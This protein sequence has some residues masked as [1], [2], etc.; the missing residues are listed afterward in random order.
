M[1]QFLVA[2]VGGN[3]THYRNIHKQ[4]Y[5]NSSY[6]RCIWFEKTENAR[7]TLKRVRSQNQFRSN[8]R[9]VCQ[10]NTNEIHRKTEK[11]AERN[12]TNAS[13]KRSSGSNEPNSPATLISAHNLQDSGPRFQCDKDKLKTV[14]DDAQNIKTKDHP[15]AIIS[16][17]SECLAKRKD[18][19]P[20]E[21]FLSKQRSKTKQLETGKVTV[22]NVSELH[23]D[24][25]RLK[26][27]YGTVSES[28]PTASS[29]DKCC[30]DNDFTTASVASTGITDQLD[31]VTTR[32]VS[33]GNEFII[34]LSCET[35][36]NNASLNNN[37]YYTF[38]PN[39]ETEHKKMSLNQP[40]KQSD[41]NQET[42]NIPLLINTLS[43]DEHKKRDN[44]TV[45]KGKDVRNTN[46]TDDSDD[47]QFTDQA[48][49][50]IWTSDTQVTASADTIMKE[51]E[52]T[53]PQRDFIKPHALLDDFVDPPAANEHFVDSD[54]SPGKHFT[55]HEDKKTKGEDNEDISR[56]IDSHG[57][58]LRLCNDVEEI[59][60]L[61]G[62]KNRWRK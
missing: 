58:E 60:G 25:A 6:D 37:V 59:R 53:N 55:N 1:Q 47:T 40:E 38:K 11:S 48:E 56:N 36:K 43:K 49:E 52:T 45:Q 32:P 35:K 34:P 15:D 22:Q 3:G 13:I 24:S 46:S 62:I 20:L 17:I 16:K 8:I 23:S 5:S 30:E 54:S 28:T 33:I 29:N 12:N 42:I 50:F 7:C 39:N 18:T 19:A 21:N 57:E 4:E 26:A 2:N 41:N 31:M 44:I 51:I 61:T 9:P 10:Y 27:E 14:V